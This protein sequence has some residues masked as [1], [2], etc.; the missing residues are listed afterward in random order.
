MNGFV[1]LKIFATALAV[2][3]LVGPVVQWLM[4]TWAALVD[5]VGAGGAWFAS[6]MYHIVYGI[7]IGAGA[8]LSV[9]LLVRRGIEVT[10]KAAAISAC[11]AI[12]LFDIGFVLIGSKAVEFSYL[13]ILLAIFS[14]ILQTVISLTPIGKAHSSPVT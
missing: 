7:I 10:V 8:A 1:N 3:V 4:P 2:T 5:D 6:I 11:I 9:S 13:A 12:I 14:F